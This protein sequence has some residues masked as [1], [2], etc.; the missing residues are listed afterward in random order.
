MEFKK[1][2]SKSALGQIISNSFKLVIDNVLEILKIIGIFLVPVFVVGFILIFIFAF[3]MFGAMI[4]SSPEEIFFAMLSVFIP[5]LI[6]APLISLLSYFG[7]GIIIKVL[8]DRYQG[9]DTNWKVGMKYIWGKKW[10]LIG[11]NI[12]IILMAIVVYMVI[13]AITGI[14][15]TITFGIGL[16][17]II[18]I[19]IAMAFII[20][21]IYVLFNSTLIIEDLTVVES[22][23]KTVSLFGRGN[24]W[25]MIGKCAA[26]SGITILIGF[27]VAIIGF[28]PIIG[29]IIMII[30]QV[31]VQ[32]FLISACNIIVIDNMEVNNIFSKGNF[33]D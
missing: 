3:G 31:Y 15:A 26:I 23:K 22:I 25:M 18:P 14:I 5:L 29:F 21:A 2:E 9:K 30:G 19:I 7:Y 6:I 13:A 24:L 4:V 8:G 27:G 11:L 32:S 20:P 17:I 1:L 28:F 10:S 16:I 33:I 12:L